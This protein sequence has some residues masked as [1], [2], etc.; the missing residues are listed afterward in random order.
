MA[1]ISKR[2]RWFVFALFTVLAVAGNGLHF[3][4]GLGHGCG[5]SHLPTSTNSVACSEHS[6][7]HATAD[8][9]HHDGAIT[10]SLADGGD[11]EDCPVCQYFT[12]AKT[13]F[14]T[15]DFDFHS[16]AVEGR[17]ATYRSLP[18]DRV[19]GAYCSRAPP[20]FG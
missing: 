14:L 13:V 19:S 8:P 18:I 3:L 10:I 9:L 11:D 16:H 17:I 6:A 20:V 7:C 4:P 2:T 15:V 5:K 12:Q 1:N